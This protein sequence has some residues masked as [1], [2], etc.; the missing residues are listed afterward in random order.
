MARSVRS[1]WRSW[2]PYLRY[3]T[4]PRIELVVPGRGVGGASVG[5]GSS[6]S[7]VSHYG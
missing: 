7:I 1:I 4:D 6:E 2:D 3:M 5:E